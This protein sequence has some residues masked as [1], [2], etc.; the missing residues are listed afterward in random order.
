MVNNI[1]GDFMAKTKSYDKSFLDEEFD[2][3]ELEFD[4]EMFD[5][6]ELEFDDD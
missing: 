3:E 2:D 1:R 4:D 5:D 6:E